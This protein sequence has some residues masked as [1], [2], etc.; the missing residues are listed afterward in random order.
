M[1]L[2]DE[3]TQIIKK[4]IATF[5]GATTEASMVS[6]GTVISVGDGI[7]RIFG[8]EGVRYMEV[9]EF[10]RTGLHALAL[11]LE[12]EVVSTPIMGDFTLIR[13]GDEVR[14]TGRIIQVPVGDALLDR[15]STRL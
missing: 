4:N 5:G 3:I 7:A 11:N 2:A 14:T 10:P 15:K 6:V 13:E 8:L 9:V 1:A 12:E